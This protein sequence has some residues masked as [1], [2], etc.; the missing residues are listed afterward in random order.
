MNRVYNAS[1]FQRATVYPTPPD[2]T[3]GLIDG[4]A[5]A[6][7]ALPGPVLEPCCDIGA[8]ASVLAARERAEGSRC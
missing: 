5:E 4:L 3:R 1:S 8:L 6:G 2:L 7:I